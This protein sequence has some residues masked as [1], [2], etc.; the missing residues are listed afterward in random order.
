MKAVVFKGPHKVEFE[1][2][3]I[4]Q[5]QESTDIIVKVEKVH[6]LTIS[7]DSRAHIRENN[8]TQQIDGA[9]WQV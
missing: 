3:P 1:D 5:I 8:L 7:S 4:P 2:R 6:I 9:M